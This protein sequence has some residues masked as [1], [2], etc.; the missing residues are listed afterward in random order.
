MGLVISKSSPEGNIFYIMA[1]AKQFL[2]REDAKKM[3]YEVTSQDL[4]EAALEVIKKYVPEI[5]FID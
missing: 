3:E 4:H 2:S 1:I 5:S